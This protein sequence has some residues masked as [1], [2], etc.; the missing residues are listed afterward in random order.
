MCVCI[1]L[2]SRKG[3]YVTYTLINQEASDQ[4]VKVDDTGTTCF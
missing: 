2:H 3:N 4:I 1:A